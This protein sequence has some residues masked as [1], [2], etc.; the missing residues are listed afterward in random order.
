MLD[1]ALISWLQG[2]L[3]L[4]SEVVVRAYCN[5]WDSWAVAC[6]LLHALLN[7]VYKL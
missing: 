7:A 2:M 5:I 6:L 3:V 1:Q 4:D